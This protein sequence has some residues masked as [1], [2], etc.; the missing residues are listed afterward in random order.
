MSAIKVIE[1]HSMVDS[2]QISVVSP[3]NLKRSL[4][5]FVNPFHRVQ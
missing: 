5:P 2:R 1:D 4:S 3:H